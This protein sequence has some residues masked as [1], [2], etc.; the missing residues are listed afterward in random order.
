MTEFSYRVVHTMD[1]DEYDKNI[2]NFASKEPIFN[3][4]YENVGPGGCL[5]EDD[6]KL[7]DRTLEYPSR[8]LI[9]IVHHFKSQDDAMM[10]SLIW[11]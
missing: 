11:S 5:E 6:N 4:L 8:R 10:F 2:L 3:W 1:K 7:W 9:S